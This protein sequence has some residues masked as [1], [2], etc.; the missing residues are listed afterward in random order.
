M[1]YMK[2]NLFRAICDINFLKTNKKMNNY[3]TLNYKST[4]KKTTCQ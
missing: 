4:T 2:L 3:I 1:Q